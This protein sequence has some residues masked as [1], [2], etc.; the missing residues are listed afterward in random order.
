VSDRILVEIV[1]V[2]EKD[3]V[4]PAQG[5]GGGLR[6]DLPE[7][8]RD[9]ALVA[10]YGV[11]DLCRHSGEDMESG[12]RTKTKARAPSMPTVIFSRHAAVGGISYRSTQASRWRAFRASCSRL[13]KA[14]SFR[15]YEMKMSNMGATLSQL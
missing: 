1:L 13:A 12:L 5:F 11:F 6:F 8:C 3:P 2:P 9:K 4:E 14:L 10:G 15:E 7:D